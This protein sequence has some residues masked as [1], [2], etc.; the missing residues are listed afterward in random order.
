M[1]RAVDESVRNITDTYTALGI[2]EDTLIV[3][4][5]D[6]GGTAD[7]GGNNYPL[8]G[9]KATPFEGGVRGLGFVAGAGLSSAVRGTVQR[10]LMHVTDWL[11]TLVSGVAGLSLAHLGRPCPTCN[12]SIAP[13]DGVDQWAM[14]STGAPSA[15]T[16]V[17]LDL[18][19]TACQAKPIPCN[20]PGSGAIRIGKW[21]LLHGHQAGFKGPATP[22]NL[23][24]CAARLGIG[25]GVNKTTLPVPANESSPICA[26][27]WNPPPRA[28]GKYE[29]PRPPSD[30]GCTGLPCNLTLDSKY[31]TGQTLLFDLEADMFEEHNVAE[32]YPEVVATLLARLQ[33]FN[34][35]HCGGS[36]C[37]PDKDGYRPSL[38][39]QG[40]PTD[41]P[42][43]PLHEPVWLPWR[44]NKDPAACDTNR[45]PPAPP[46]PSP[47]EGLKSNFK[48]ATL[49]RNA[50]NALVLSGDGW[51]FD[52]AWP[53]GGVP[54]MTVRLS[55]DGVPATNVLANLTRPKTFS[56][57]TGAPNLNHGFA[58]AERGPWVDKLGGPGSHRLDV[59]VFLD[60]VVVPSTPTTA[61]SPNSPVCFTDGKPVACKTGRV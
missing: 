18:Q 44:G 25:Q 50:R 51:C 9:Q 24:K 28:D 34:L 21:K 6:N 3:F 33:Q 45:D 35:S 56:N 53:G 49:A 2:M 22:G 20:I 5:T 26:F 32:A 38:G 61:V 40:T 1:V 23:P 46:P 11:P 29:L 8:R 41:D 14:L 37:L 31:L 16:E 10:G 39:P 43:F 59:D 30:A 54:A 36:R 12:R 17:L 60:P 52:T 7:A 13:L 48:G 57:S 27:G 47:K 42:A 55:V 4:S 19:A 58:F 15:R